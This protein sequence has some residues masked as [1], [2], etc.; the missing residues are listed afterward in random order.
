MTLS[1]AVRSTPRR[2][3]TDDKIYLGGRG[4]AASSSSSPAR[5]AAVSCDDIDS[6]L[7]PS[8]TKDFCDRPGCIAGKRRWPSGARDIF[9]FGA[10][11]WGHGGAAHVRRR[12]ERVARRRLR[13]GLQ[14]WPTDRNAETLIVINNLVLTAS[15]RP[16][17]VAGDRRH[18][19]ISQY[20]IGTAHAGGQCRTRR[21]NVADFK[22]SY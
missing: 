5:R 8:R 7:S 15:A 6:S 13:C 10:A 3:P 11:F 20:I 16:S 1:T 19:S 4:P 22:H 18:T 17:V 2:P 12:R 14:G 21:S 9:G